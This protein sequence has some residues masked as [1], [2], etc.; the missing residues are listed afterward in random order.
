VEIRYARV[1]SVLTLII[2]AAVPL[3]A[4]AQ[5][6]VCQWKPTNSEPLRTNKNN[7]VE[8]GSTVDP[9]VGGLWNTS[10]FVVNLDSSGSRNVSWQVAGMRVENLKPQQFAVACHEAQRGRTDPSGPLFFGRDQSSLWTEIYSAGVA[11]TRDTYT[12]Q[13][14]N[15]TSQAIVSSKDGK[16]PGLTVKVTTTLEKTTTGYRITYTIENLSKQDA[17]IDFPVDGAV[18]RLQDGAVMRL[19]PGEKRTASVDSATFPS[20][21]RF[22]VQVSEVPKDV[23][24]A[25]INVPTAQQVVPRGR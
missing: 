8:W 3:T 2:L 1:V 17:L 18:T 10:T 13:T 4:F 5:L 20:M 12:G 19:K 14:L 23:V 25:I 9:A 15:L 21:I 11:A 22:P 7:I 6:G 24:L 16:N